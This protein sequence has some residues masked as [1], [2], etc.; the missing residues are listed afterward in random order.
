MHIARTPNHKRPYKQ[1]SVL[2]ASMNLSLARSRRRVSRSSRSSSGNST[3]SQDEGLTPAGGN[4]SSAFSSLSLQQSLRGQETPT[5]AFQHITSHPESQA[6]SRAV[7][8]GVDPTL[9]PL[10][11]SPFDSQDPC[12]QDTP[13]IQ[14]FADSLDLYL[15]T[16]SDAPRLEHNDNP[17]HLDSS[18]PASPAKAATGLPFGFRQRP[19]HPTDFYTLQSS[20]SESLDSGTELCN[21]DIS[22]QTTDGDSPLVFQYDPLPQLK[23]L[24]FDFLEDSVDLNMQ[25]PTEF[26]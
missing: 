14:F 5:E 1:R 23:D 4:V 18:L 20:N 26:G 10:I 19:I 22:V 15:T 13:W 17:A 21:Q 7:S 6:V 11:S 25:A 3:S 8:A 12:I 24:N 9:S 16:T 2:A